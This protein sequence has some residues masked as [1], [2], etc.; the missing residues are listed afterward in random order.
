MSKVSVLM[1]AYNSERYIAKAIES[2]LMQTHK[3]L[4]IICI[5]DVSTDNTYSIIKEYAAQ[6]LEKEQSRIM[7]RVTR[8]EEKADSAHKRIDKLEERVN[9]N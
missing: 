5:D 8:N 9:E 6:V 7:E 1:A 2:L 3:D 4:Q